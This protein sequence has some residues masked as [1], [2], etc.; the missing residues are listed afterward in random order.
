M[1]EYFVDIDLTICIT[2]MDDKG[3]PDYPSA[4]PCH[5]NIQIINGLF[6]EGHR[7]TYWTTRGAKTGIDWHD[8][9]EKQLKA[10]GC[11]YHD[12]RLDKP[13]YDY[14]IDDKALRLPDVF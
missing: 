1:K 12:L 5:R 3:M 10:W 13:Y 14:I 2:P 6:D 9:T 4:I 11:K 8:L 7:I